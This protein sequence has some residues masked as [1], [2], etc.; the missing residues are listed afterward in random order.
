M[1]LL[2]RYRRAIDKCYVQSLND[3]ETEPYKSKYEARKLFEELYNL[4]TPPIAS[5]L[6]K[7]FDLI[8]ENDS[9]KFVLAESSNSTIEIKHRYLIRCLLDYHIATIYNDTEEQNEGES[10][11]N[12]LL[13]SIQSVLP[14]PILSSLGL[15]IYNQLIIIRT[16]YDDYQ[17]AIEYARQA[18]QLYNQ[19]IQF[20]CYLLQE[21]I[22]IDST[23]STNERREE[24]EQIYTHT[25]FYLAQIYGKLN[26]K[27]QS[28]TYCRRTLERQLSL[29]QNG[30]TKYFDPLDW[31]TNCATLSQ[32]YM[33]NHDY[34]TARY[35]LQCADLILEQIRTTNDKFLERHASFQR[36]WIKYAVNLLSKILIEWSDELNGFGS[37]LIERAR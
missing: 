17:Q 22:E 4:D 32:Y 26:D 16:S 3:P 35:C 6:V 23:I 29:Y 20:D 7:D 27:N 12:S 10:R 33:T 8:H 13:Q 31:S 11:L 21:I 36:C 1:T 28:A 25:L 19:S 15:N 2:E 37:N 30:Q 24:F 5:D 34:A 14:H 9:F 18:E